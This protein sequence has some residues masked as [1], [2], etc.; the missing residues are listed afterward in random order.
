[1]KKQP[2]FALTI[3]FLLAGCCTKPPET[4]LDPDLVVPWVWEWKETSYPIENQMGDWS[5]VIGSSDAI[6][7]PIEA[8][9]ECY[10]KRNETHVLIERPSDIGRL[11]GIVLRE[12]TEA[13]AFVRMF[14]DSET[15][16]LFSFPDAVE[17]DME[18]ATIERKGNDFLVTRRLVF[19]ED[20]DDEKGYPVAIVKEKVT[21]DG[22]YEMISKEIIDWLPFAIT[23]FKMFQ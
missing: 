18:L 9:V 22:Q 6:G 4:P 7:D 23:G 3:G 5:F 15:Y 11:R 20:E 19:E 17:K 8:F 2:F 16:W 12:T 21:R 1:M 10:A 14:T 13:M